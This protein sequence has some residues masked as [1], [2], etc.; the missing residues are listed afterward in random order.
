MWVCCERSTN[1][2]SQFLSGNL[3]RSSASPRCL[4]THRRRGSLRACPPN[5]W[6]DARISQPRR[7]EWQPPTL[8]SELRSRPTIH[9]S[10]SLDREDLKAPPSPPCSPD[11]AGYG[12]WDCPPS[13]QSSTGEDAVPSTTRRVPLTTFK[14]LPIARA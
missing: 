13:A 10:T 6:K 4:S 1:T 5:C 3:P 14:S 9:W 12:L 8:R 2:R 11:L 7:E